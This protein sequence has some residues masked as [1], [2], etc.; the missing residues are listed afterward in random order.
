MGA[1]Y[2]AMLSTLD[3]SNM[4]LACVWAYPNL[5]HQLCINILCILPHSNRITAAVTL[6]L[7]GADDKEIAFRLQ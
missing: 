6:K 5:A 2:C 1:R 3:L 4:H 7:G